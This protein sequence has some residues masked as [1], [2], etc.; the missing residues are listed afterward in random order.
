MIA[1]LVVSLLVAV[2][3]PGHHVGWDRGRYNPH[4]RHHV[5]VVHPGPVLINPPPCPI[6]WRHPPL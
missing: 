2:V 6:V 5:C 3:P 4:H 1:A